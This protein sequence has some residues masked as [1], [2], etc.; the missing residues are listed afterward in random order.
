MKSWKERK[1][2]LLIVYWQAGGHLRLIWFWAENRDRIRTNVVNRGWQFWLRIY[3][4]LVHV[5]NCRPE[6]CLVN[7][8]PD[9]P[10]VFF[11]KYFPTL[12]KCLLFFWALFVA[13]RNITFNLVVEWQNHWRWTFWR[14]SLNMLSTVI[15]FEKIFGVDATIL[16]CL[17]STVELQTLY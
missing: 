14:S 10:K 5:N 2:C 7:P 13:R 12:I 3:C 15:S 8:W 16:H 6:D 9:G 1:L 4:A 17:R 11:T